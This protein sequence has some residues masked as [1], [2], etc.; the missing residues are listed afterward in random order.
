GL[1]WQGTAVKH[2]LRIVQAQAVGSLLAVGLCQVLEPWPHGRWTPG[3]AMSI[4]GD[5]VHVVCL[6]ELAA[7]GL[8]GFS[9]A[10]PKRSCRDL[11]EAP[12]V[13]PLNQWC[14]IAH[15]RWISLRVCDDRRYAGGE[16]AEEDIVLDAYVYKIGQFDQQVIRPVNGELRGL[17][18]K[19][20]QVLVRQMKVAAKS[21][22]EGIAEVFL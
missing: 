13:H 18:L 3:E 14:R 1:R 22:G 12:H 15:E 21:E 16:D 19:L 5:Q 20:L 9:E 8:R 11:D 2:G 17:L 6:E 4:A 7:E 10:A